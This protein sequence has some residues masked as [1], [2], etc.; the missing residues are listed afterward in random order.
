LPPV[1]NPLN[2]QIVTAAQSCCRGSI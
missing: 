1:G 2:P